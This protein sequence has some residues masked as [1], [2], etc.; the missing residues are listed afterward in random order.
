[1]VTHRAAAELQAALASTWSSPLFE[2][3]IFLIFSLSSLS[4]RSLAALASCKKH[5]NPR[6][7]PT[8]CSARCVAS[9]PASRSAP[10]ARSGTIAV[11]L[12]R[13]NHQPIC[14]VEKSEKMR[15]RPSGPDVRPSGCRRLRRGAALGPSRGSGGGGTDAGCRTSW[16]G[17]C[18]CCGSHY[19]CGFCPC[20]CPR[21]ESC[22]GRRVSTVSAGCGCVTASIETRMWRRTGCSDGS[23]FWTGCGSRYGW[24][25]DHGSGFATAS[26]GGAWVPANHGPTTQSGGGRVGTGSAW[27]CHDELRVCGNG[28][29]IARAVGV[30]RGWVTGWRNACCRQC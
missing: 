5:V 15:K 17:F 20:F 12:H 19:G 16:R 9:I 30:A 4:R 25:S 26:S 2:D 8:V 7:H 22:S 24:D 23:G 6:H 14:S 1:M 10:A 28:N 29:G 11:C 18:F 21:R 27:P 3:L 13:L